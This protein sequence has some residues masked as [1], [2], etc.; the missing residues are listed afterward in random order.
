MFKCVFAG[1]G[2]GKTTYI[3]NSIEKIKNY[4]KILII[5]Y[6]NSCVE[7]IEERIE[8]KDK[9]LLEKIYISQDFIFN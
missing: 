1:A 3:L 9:H 8:K 6:T 4:K 5:T 2:C 7:E